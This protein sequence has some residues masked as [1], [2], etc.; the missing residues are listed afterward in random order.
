[1]SAK[2]AFLSRPLKDDEE[3]SF[4]GIPMSALRKVGEQDIVFRINDGV[5]HLVSVRVGRSWDD[6]VEILS[7]LSEGDTVVLNPYE[8]LESGRRVSVRE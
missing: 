5:A 4:V 6:T 3:K 8:R 7:G 1:M 2:V